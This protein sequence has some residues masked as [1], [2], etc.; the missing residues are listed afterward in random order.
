MALVVVSKQPAEGPVTLNRRDAIKIIGSVLLTSGWVSSGT[1]SRVSHVTDGGPTRGTINVIL[2]NENG[3]VV[4]TDSLLSTRGPDGGIQQL[5]RPGKK[6]FKLD[7][8]TVCT[9]AGLTEVPIPFAELEHT[10]P[11]ILQQYSVQLTEI[12]EDR[13]T[14]RLSIREKIKELNYI[15]ANEIQLLADIRNI[16]T[17]DTDYEVQLTLAGYDPDGTTRIAWS[18]LKIDRSNKSD[19][20]VSASDPE[21]EEVVRG[22]Q[23]TSMVRGIPDLAEEIIHHPEGY[24]D[25]A[26]ISRYQHSKDDGHALTVE[27][28]KAF[29]QSL[30]HRTAAIDHRVGGKDQI[31]V[32]EGGSI[33]ELHQEPFPPENY[34]TRRFNI[35]SDNIF[36]PH[37]PPNLIGPIP[38]VT[39]LYVNNKFRGN[40]VLL[41]DS[42]FAANTFSNCTVMYSGGHTI[43]APGQDTSSSTLVLSKEVSRESGT[44]SHLVND[45]HW[46]KINDNRCAVGNKNKCDG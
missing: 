13:P 18:D 15:L 36:D 2:G 46:A 8:T 4:L 33:V 1:P 29:A 21:E 44:A 37:P 19:W 31:A 25:D 16:P 41:D 38:N 39:H 12:E 32:L 35:I 5:E 40:N 24:V 26:P 20:L 34:R 3:L 42:Y 7:S 22:P 10:I 43:F 28:M 23:L 14:H 30:A 45:F 9:L 27:E 6:L 17:R 11:S